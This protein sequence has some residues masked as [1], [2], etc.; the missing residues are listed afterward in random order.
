MFWK[1]NLISTSHV[2]TILNKENVTLKELMDEE[3]ILQECKSQ[4]KKLI[5]FLT[6]PEIMEELVTLITQEPSEEIEEKSRYKYPNVACEL[7]TSEVIAINDALAGTEMHLSKLYSFIDTEKPL[8]PL[9]ASFFSKTMSL[10]INKKTEVTFEFIRSKEDF[11]SLILNHIETS[12][13]MDL[14]LRMVMCTENNDTHSAIVKWL[15]EQNIIKRLIWMIDPVYNEDQNSNAAHTLCDIVKITRDHMSLLQENAD[16]DPLLDALQSSAVIGELLDHMFQNEK[17]ESVLVSGI[18]VILSLLEFKRQGPAGQFQPSQMQQFSAQAES[19]PQTF[20]SLFFRNDGPEQMTELDADRLNKG[21]DG[22]LAAITPRLA[23]L[24]NLLVNPPI[25]PAFSTTV[26]PLEPPLG[27]TRLEVAQLLSALINTN[28]HLVNTEL[29]NLGTIPILLD[30]FF[31]YSWNNFLHTQVEQLVGTILQNSP[32]SDQEDNKVQPLLDQLFTQGKV[33][34]RLLDAWEENEQE[35]CKP[36]KHRK[37]YM[38]HLI[39]VANHIAQNLDSGN[40]S[41]IISLRLKE[42]PEEYQKQWE[43]F[44]SEALADINKKQQ[45]PLVMAPITNATL[46]ED[47]VEFRDLPYNQDTALQQAFSDYQ[48]QQMTNNFVDQFGFNDEEFLETEQTMSGQLD[49]LAKVNFQFVPENNAK[50][51]ELFEQSCRDRINPIADVD[52]DEDVWDDKE[53]EITFAA[54]LNTDRSRL[55]AQNSGDN[56]SDSDEDV[57]KPNMI[58]SLPIPTSRIVT[59]EIKMDVDQNDPWN[60]AFAQPPDMPA[61]AMDTTNPWDVGGRPVGPTLDTLPTSNSGDQNWADF[62]SF[63]PFSSNEFSIPSPLERTIPK[64]T[65]GLP[66]EGSKVAATEKPLIESLKENCVAN[67]L[68]DDNVRIDSIPVPDAITS[69]DVISVECKKESSVEEQHEIVVPA[70]PPLPSQPNL[71][72]NGPL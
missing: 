48:M 56:S 31:K 7:L 69:V 4:N 9:L 6:Q 64:E 58:S 3:D 10:L 11:L 66:F 68:Q 72:Q 60:S 37:G 38:G 70:P 19:A 65:A 57:Q 71:V 67:A 26:G 36:G 28:N 22:V 21:V 16:P 62:S 40:N 1:F 44:S 35:Q 39:K 33:I 18:L 12:A 2:D 32:T 8:N 14:L 52:S 47:C 63:S 13:I 45:S 27:W 15:N 55:T 34:Q 29:S 53:Q 46:D 50:T 54:G 61:V 5:D 43:T 20:A 41:D 25:K 24:T 23:D 51:T 59:E 49:G 42:L 17:R 30:L